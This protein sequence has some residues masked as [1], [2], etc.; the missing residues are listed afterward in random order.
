MDSQTMNEKL[1]SAAQE[2]HQLCNGKTWRMCIPRR[3][4]DS[5]ALIGEAISIGQH[6]VAENANLSEKLMLVFAALSA[7][8][9]RCPLQPHEQWAMD[10]TRAHF[11]RLQ[12]E[13]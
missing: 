9:M 8:S 4:D 13:A 12:K 7:V 5:D 1:W 3:K 10:S 11:E 6:L 2:V